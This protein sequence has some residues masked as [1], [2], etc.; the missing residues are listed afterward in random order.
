MQ[1]FVKEEYSAGLACARL[2]SIDKEFKAGDLITRRQ[3]EVARTRAHRCF[4]FASRRSSDSC[5]KQSR[6]CES[7]RNSGSHGAD[8][9]SERTADQFR[10]GSLPA[11]LLL[12]P[13]RAVVSNRGGD[14]ISIMLWLDI[15]PRAPSAAA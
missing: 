15:S 8:R 12:S 4:F 11:R 13:T 14:Q 10:A 3:T 9:V 6:T 2:F 1:A 5:D 7:H